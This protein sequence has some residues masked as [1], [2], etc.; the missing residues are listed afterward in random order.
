MTEV[1][2]RTPQ[3][4]ARQLDISPATLRRWSD[5][6]ADQLSAEAR[7]T[8]GKSHRRYSEA[9]L[10]ALQAVKNMMGAGMTYEQVRQ[11][12]SS[13]APAT[14]G[15]ETALINPERVG[16]S[17]AFLSTAI[18]NITESHRS[19]LNSQQANRELM[20]VV[21]QDNFNLKEE[22][23]R[24]RERMLEIERQSA[25]LRRDHELHIES[26]RQEIEM[27]LLEIRETVSLR[28]RITVL[29]NQPGCLGSLFGG[30]GPTR[31][32]TRPPPGRRGQ[33][34]PGARPRRPP[35]P[36]GPPE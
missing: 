21:I 26:M 11:H 22:N 35:M 9:D 34:P 20:G 36:P 28:N 17:M 1:S 3:E 5:E 24:L 4:V 33:R 7:S 29:A 8:Q 10:E 25:Q 32:E 14:D 2:F 16:T 15:E 18:E 13:H 23:T 19:V 31:I 6:F 12:L 27:K 30:G